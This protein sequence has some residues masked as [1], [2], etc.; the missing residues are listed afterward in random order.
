M[1]TAKID[2]PGVTIEL[3]ATEASIEALGKQAMD[4]YREASAINSATLTG[5]AFGLNNEKRWTPDH[6]DH[7]R[8]AGFAPVKAEGER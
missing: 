7:H 2:T 3:T 1:P 5:P 8:K 6:R 4:M